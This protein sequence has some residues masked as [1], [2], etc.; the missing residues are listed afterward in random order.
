MKR[1]RGKKKPPRGKSFIQGKRGTEKRFRLGS[2]TTHPS[3]EKK[4]AR[5]VVGVGVDNV[6]V[7]K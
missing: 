6:E 1:G 7:R 2:K 3:W 5:M 4:R